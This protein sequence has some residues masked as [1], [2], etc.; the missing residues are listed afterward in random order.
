MTPQK[1]IT[2]L[3]KLI[4]TL[5]H[6]LIDKLSAIGTLA[7][8]LIST[9][10]FAQ[11]NTT[12]AGGNATGAGGSVSYS[13]GQI[14]YITETGAGGKANQ[15]VQQPVAPC[16]TVTSSNVVEC[17][18]VPVSLVGSP[19][20]GVF[21]I[22]NPYL[23]PTTNYTYTYIDMS[24]GCSV[25][26]SPSTV[27]LSAVTPPVV[28]PF[29][30]LTNSATITWTAVPGATTYYMWYRK[31]GDIT[32]I[33]PTTASTSLTLT[34]L[35]PNSMYE[36]K[37]RC[38]NAL[39]AQ[40]G[41]FGSLMNFTTAN[42]PC[43]TPTTFITAFTLTSTTALVKWVGLPS[44]AQYSLWYKKSSDA[45]WLTLMFTGSTT[46]Y[47]LTGLVPNTSYD[48]KIRNRCVGD[49][50]FTPFGSVYTFGTPPRAGGGALVSNQNIH[51]F[52]N[53]TN[54]ILN[55]EIEAIGDN[56]MT[57]KLLDITGRLLKQIQ[58]NTNVGLN[59]ISLSMKELAAGNYNLQVYENEKLIHLS[60]V[61]KYD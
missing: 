46:Q 34:G 13:V 29:T 35:I 2:N 33:T 48:V 59:N 12:A 43:G 54:D 5:P 41:P 16:P 18:G 19:P 1:C 8:L 37:M 61:S 47:L 40:Y 11:Q 31:V 27:F 21:S 44:V 20:G 32:W 6:W 25:T 30:P 3:P 36:F 17:P 39:C 51:I 50:T 28:N 56:S 26:S 22:A 14:D 49:L 24:I 15:G 58:T 10:A 60:K 45:T 57:I 23:G 55:I 7:Y 9:S 4:G 53:P 38:N 52:P 42:A